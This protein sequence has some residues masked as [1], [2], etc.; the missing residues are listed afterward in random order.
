[1]LQ[2][3]TS[4]SILLSSSFVR[5]QSSIMASALAAQYNLATSTS[6]PFP[7]ATLTSTDT[8]S[9]IVS[10]WSL[11]KGHIQDGEGDLSFVANPFP[12]SPPISPSDT[13]SS[14]GNS[15][16]LQVTYPQGSFSH[17]SG[18]SQFYNLWNTS[19]G[20][21]FGSMLLS[22]EMAFD[23]DF[24]W[25]KG[26]KLPGLRGGLE[27]SGCS[28]GDSVPNGKDCFS[29]RVMWR[30][31]AE[32]E[33]YAYI[34]TPNGLCDAKDVI[35]NSDFGTSFNRGS[36]G[37]LPGRWLRLAMLVQL[38]NPPHIANGQIQLY[39]NDR[40]AISQTGLQIRAADSLAINGL[41]FSTFFGGSDKSW[42]TPTTQHTYFRNI[43]MWGSSAMSNLTGQEVSAGFVTSPTPLI[44]LIFLS[45]ICLWI[46]SFH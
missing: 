7:S 43:Q 5:A 36:F 35:C 46:L 17:E 34:P 42:A 30:K 27:S 16:V 32:G 28:G 20:S 45:T 2:L 11:G 38:N 18:G 40:L 4:L 33:V 9:H 29:S 15:T 41:Y 25:V 6:L 13:P 22:Y 39:Y 26:G 1:M 24:N 14:S 8:A 10:Q 12:S 23:S 31:F 21:T 44:S 3:L 19:D 37:F